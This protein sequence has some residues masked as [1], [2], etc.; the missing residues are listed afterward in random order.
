[1]GKEKKQRVL[2]WPPR[3]FQW[4]EN[5]SELE[6]LS[7]IYAKLESLTAVFSHFEKASADRPAMASDLYGFWFILTDIC[8]DLGN[9]LKVD[10]WTGETGKA[11]ENE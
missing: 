7:V 6:R 11:D 2:A 4:I 5:I 10:Y 9:I 3:D 1:M 8:R